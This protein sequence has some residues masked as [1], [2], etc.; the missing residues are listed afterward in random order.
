MS[1]S[2]WVE[3]VTFEHV[4]V[5]FFVHVQCLTTKKNSGL[6]WEGEA[7]AVWGCYDIRLKNKCFALLCVCKL[8]RHATHWTFS[9]VLKHTQDLQHFVRGMMSAVIKSVKRLQMAAKRFKMAPPLLWHHPPV[10]RGNTHSEEWAQ[11]WSRAQWRQ[12]MLP[13]DGDCSVH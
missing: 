6:V 5:N 4:Q 11:P 8:M 12:T 13:S 10:H 2:C 1:D 7:Q 3:P 9:E